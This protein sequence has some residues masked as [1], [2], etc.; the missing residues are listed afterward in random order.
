MIPKEIENKREYLN[1]LFAKHKI[2]SAFA[3]GSV[4]SGK[5]HQESDLDFLVII[6]EGIDPVEAGGHLWDLE[7]ELQELFE[8]EVDL[9]TERSLKNPYFIE[10]VNKTKV[11]IYG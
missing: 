10:E 8:R 9:I 4:V 3:F 11:Q 1:K 7:E 6:L 5:F 2:E